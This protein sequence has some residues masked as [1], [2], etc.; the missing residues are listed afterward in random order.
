MGPSAGRRER[1]VLGVALVAGSLGMVVLASA[2]QAGATTR[3][4]LYVNATTGTNTT[5][6]TGP[7]AT[8]CKTIQEGVTA[9][10]ACTG[11]A[12]TITV[13][14]GS[15][16]GGI[17]ITSSKLT[18]LTIEGAGA[19]T[20]DVTGGGS[21]RDFDVSGGTVTIAGVSINLGHVR[22]IMT[23]VGTGSGGGVYTHGT[24]TLTHDTFSKDSATF[25]GAVGNSYAT[26]TLTDDTFSTDLAYYAGGAVSNNVGT[27][28]VTDDTFSKD[29]AF[30]TGEEGGALYSGGFATATVTDDT[31]SQDSSNYGGAIYV[32]GIHS[33]VSATDDTFS[34]DTA[35]WR[36]VQTGGWYTG[37]GAIYDTTGPL[38]ITA[39]VLDRSTCINLG[40]FL[41]A[42]YNVVT[43]NTCAS[44]GTEVT[45]STLDLTTTLKANTSSGPE[46]LS[47]GPT[48]VA[49]DE[50]P[51]TACTVKTDER[52]DPRPGLVGQAACDAGAYELQHTPVSLTQGT[53]KTG[54]ATHGLSTMFHLAVTAPSATTGRVMFVSKRSAPT[55]VNLTPTGT[56]R[57]AATTAGGRYR[58]AGTDA[59]PLGDRGTWTFVLH[60]TVRAPVITSTPTATFKVGRRSV[61]NITATGQ[62]PV[63]LTE[64]GTLPTGLSFK[65][66]KRGIATIAGKPAQTSGGTYALAIAA[67]NKFGQYRQSFTLVVGQAPA[68][69]SGATAT[70]TAGATNAFTVTTSGYP[71]ASITESGTL[72]YGVT[73]T[74]E[75][76]GTASISGKPTTKVAA[77]RYKLKLT[78]TNGFGKA[79][80]QKF[81]L[82]VS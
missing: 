8:A 52:G 55:G 27:V 80:T 49:I 81:T 40:R 47:L 12:V 21:E 24:V 78:A 35:R 30:G 59:D 43:T 9:A 11:D 2:P 82:T 25:G 79:A 38:T 73:F 67:S 22:Q 70:F 51:K 28:T 68:L 10:E 31:F 1:T 37:G 14:G 45:A 61:F 3:V 26:A 71:A 4:T 53:P 33:A 77:R 19:S 36:T 15:Y 46:T 17:T 76:N 16:T 75:G 29:T 69:T 5:G 18:S 13:A 72:P 63:E 48:S 54:T 41:S 7:V 62:G 58:L 23:G 74:T 34:G 20:T 50:V 66:H 65:T 56:I 57:V 60:V 32:S 39:S 6:C 64:T 42:R 44:L